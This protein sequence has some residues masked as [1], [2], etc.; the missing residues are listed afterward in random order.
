MS[1]LSPSIVNLVWGK[2]IIKWNNQHLCFKDVMLAPNLCIEW[3]WNKSN[4]HHDSGIQ[5][6]D[7]KT[8]V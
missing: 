3:D 1:R 2:V 8:L 6:Q 7:I 4:T 5:V